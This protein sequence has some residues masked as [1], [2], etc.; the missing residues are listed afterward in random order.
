MNVF[1]PEGDNAFDDSNI[2]TVQEQLFDRKTRLERALTTSQN[3]LQLE[4]LP[5]EADAALTPD[6]GWHLWIV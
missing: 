4:R 3:T 2:L 5:S 1:L 6:Q